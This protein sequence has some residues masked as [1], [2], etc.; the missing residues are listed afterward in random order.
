ML[1]SLAWCLM[2]PFLAATPAAQ[3]SP[4]TPEEVMRLPNDIAARL[5]RDIAAVS[6]SPERRVELLVDFISSQGGM[7]FRYQAQPT[8]H[9]SDT[10]RQTQGN[11]LSFTLLFISMARSL[12]LDVYPREVRVP[13]SWRQ[14]AGVI[15]DIGH[16]NVGVSTPTNRKTVDF[17]PDFLLSQRLAAPYRGRRISDERALAHFYNNRAAELLSAGDAVAA[18]EWAG[19]AL[20]LEPDFGPAH[21]TLGVAERRLGRIDPARRRFLEALDLSDDYDSS[22]A[23]FNLILLERAAGQPEAAQRHV[24]ALRERRRDDPWFQWAIGRFFDDLGEPAAPLNFMPA[25]LSRN[26]S[27]PRRSGEIELAPPTAAPGLR[28]KLDKFSRP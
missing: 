19:Q 15:F 11:C 18:R 21:N 17:E 16:V 28:R 20:A 9:V 7:G 13:A 10:V 8:L 4:P 6:R 24:L 2:V 27:C 3:A 22:S 1:V 14:D 26:F 5:Q 23:L 25:P 12:G